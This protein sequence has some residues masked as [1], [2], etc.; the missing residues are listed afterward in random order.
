M[1]LS[2]RTFLAAAAAVGASL[3]VTP[4]A[5]A[6]ELLPRTR[7][8]RVVIVG[9][10]WSGLSAAKR[11]RDLAPELE[12][13]LLERNAEFWSGPLSNKWLAGLIGESLLVHDYKAA[14]AAY[15]YSFVRAEASAIDRDQRRVVTDQ[16]AVGYDWLIVGVGIRYAYEA[17]Y[18]D[19]RRAALHTQA[20]FPCAYVPG[21]EARQLKRM[22]DEFQGGDLVMTIPPMPYRCPPSPYERACAIGSLLKS[23]R[24]KGKLIVIDPNP[25][26]LAFNRSFTDVYRDQIVYMRQTE[27]K[28]VDPFNRRIVTEFDDVRFDAGI[29]MAPQQAGD[30]AW[31]AGLVVRDGH[32]RGWA[33]ADPVHLHALDDKDIFLVGDLVGT[34]SPLFNAYPKSGHVA[35]SLG[36][37]A[38]QEIAAR[39]HELP[40]PRL[41]P[42]SL[43]HSFIGFDPMEAIR[44]RA[45]Y[46][47]RGD[48]LIVQNS[49]QEYDPN[50]RDEDIRWAQAHFAEFLAY[51]Q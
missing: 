10:G 21:N 14:A 20:N 3:A 51:R 48:G 19:D 47:F 11:L 37:I 40:P 7:K 43:C 33:A 28:S 23:R 35:A 6:T 42:E 29:L 34:V 30:L 46:R 49:S 17:W 45:S 41:L 26:A 4:S 39:A 44:F 12:V 5:L 8:R 18:G 2:R 1:P 9:G 16:G 13:V 32:G 25:T 24:I 15:G 50:P 22:L 27:V 38:A 36:R 31:Q